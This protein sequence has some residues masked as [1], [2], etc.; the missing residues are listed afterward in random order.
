MNEW[1]RVVSTFKHTQKDN[2]WTINFIFIYT[3]HLHAGPTFIIDKN[4]PS[5][6]GSSR[7]LSTSIFKDQVGS[8]LNVPKR[9]TWERKTPL[10]LS[11]FAR[12]YAR[13]IYSSSVQSTSI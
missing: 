5:I 4:V 2:F 13:K 3:F 1:C 12:K 8:S 6:Y 10:F 9:S 11:S 7:F